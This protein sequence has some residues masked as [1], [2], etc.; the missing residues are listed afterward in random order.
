[1]LDLSSKY[2]A[3]TLDEERAA[4]L[5]AG[6]SLLGRGEDFT[7]GAFPGFLLA[8]VASV[9]MGVAVATGRVLR[10]STGWAGIVGPSCLLVFTTWVT[11]VRGAFSPFTGLAVIGGILSLEWYALLAR[12]LTQLRKRPE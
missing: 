3:A 2:A 7:P 1:M 5:G 9:L 6:Q 4:L 11:F 8:S 12:G 10:A